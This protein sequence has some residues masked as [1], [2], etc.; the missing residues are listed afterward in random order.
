MGVVVVLQ[1]GLLRIEIANN[2]VPAHRDYSPHVRVSGQIG[3]RG[4]HMK[5][6][7]DLRISG[8]GLN[9]QE[10]TDQLSMTPDYAYKKGDTYI[11]CKHD[12]KITVYEEDCWITGYNA[13][14]N[15]N[16]CENIEDFLRKLESSSTY[17]KRLAETNDVTIWVTAHLDSE[18]ANI[19]FTL[20]TI[21]SLSKIGATLDCNVAFLKDFY[22]GDY[23]NS[24]G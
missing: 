20:P 16:L 15:K 22:S 1:E 7:I 17:I 11:D 18:Q 10:I 12:G 23:R 9:L 6:Y 19:H 2:A 13:D 14:G 3:E 4:S 5:T 8:S 24:S 21:N